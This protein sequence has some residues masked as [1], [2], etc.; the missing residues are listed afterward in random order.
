MKIKVI[1]SENF[2]KKAI[3]KQITKY[4]KVSIYFKLFLIGLLTILINGC[5][6]DAVKSEEVVF[7][8]SKI[9]GTMTDQDGNTYK[10]IT[11]GTQ[12]WMAENLRV[13]KYSNGD[14]IPNVSD[15]ATWTA[16]NTGAYCNYNNTTDKDKIAMYGRLYNWF[17][18]SDSRS[19]APVGW[20][21]PSDAEW[22][23]LMALLDYDVAGGKMKETGNNHWGDPNVG[24]TNESVF[25]ALP[26]GYRSGM[27]GVTFDGLGS[28]CNWWTATSKDITFGW[29]NFAWFRNQYNLYASPYHHYTYKQFGYSIRLVKD[30][31]IEP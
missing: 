11:I 29:D 18:I 19:I 28:C 1:T 17:T 23:A 4:M 8:P 14:T 22:S 7:N 27:A 3:K 21:V 9:Y 16:L 30:S 13:T 12:T 26:A 20:H 31:P 2:R 5:K 24:A 10:T 15:D 6:K 25:T